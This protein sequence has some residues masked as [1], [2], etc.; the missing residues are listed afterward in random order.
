M[1]HVKKIDPHKYICDPRNLR[2]PNQPRKFC[3]YVTHER[4]YPRNPR[5]KTLACSSLTLA[6]SLVVFFIEKFKHQMPYVS[7]YLVELEMS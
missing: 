6:D 1:I 3:T 4:R 5:N 7:T 2:H